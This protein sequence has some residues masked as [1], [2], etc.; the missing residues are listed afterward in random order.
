MMQ[1]IVKIPIELHFIN[2]FI[3]KNVQEIFLTFLHLC[4][5]Q[6]CLLVNDLEYTPAFS[7]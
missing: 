7:G 2:V 3:R 1:N 6:F 4:K 5:H